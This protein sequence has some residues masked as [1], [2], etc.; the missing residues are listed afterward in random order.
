MFLKFPEN[1]LELKNKYSA[2]W[3][4]TDQENLIE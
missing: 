4:I 2:Y 1:N 3:K